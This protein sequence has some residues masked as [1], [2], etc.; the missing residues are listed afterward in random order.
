[1]D[2]ALSDGQRLKKDKAE[3]EERYF[4]MMSLAR[5]NK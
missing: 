4:A 2:F 5:L 3:D 1:V